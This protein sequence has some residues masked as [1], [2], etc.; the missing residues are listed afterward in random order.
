MRE[1]IG[2]R[3]C[4]RKE[5]VVTIDGPAGAG[6]S[7]AARELA[8]RLGFRLLDTGAMYR[9]LNLKALQE[10]VNLEKERA[11]TLVELVEN[12]RFIFELPEYEPELLRKQKM[13]EPGFS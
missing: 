1:G 4:G 11:T 13:D 5:P 9:A 10:K 3:G 6:K 8:R 12:V 7:R 2:V